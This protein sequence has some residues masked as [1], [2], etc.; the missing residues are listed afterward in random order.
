[1]S[2]ITSI[3]N[4]GNVDAAA[5]AGSAIA[6]LSHTQL[7]QKGVYR[8][9]AYASVGGAPGANDTDNIVITCGSTTLALPIQPVS[10]PSGPISFFV[11]VDGASDVVARIGANACVAP[12]SVTLT[13]EYMG[14]SGGL[15]R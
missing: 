2:G 9:T 14:A 1:M 5:A 12:Y 4:T 10:G 3:F 13:A 8:V 7:T 6:T 15:R 11:S